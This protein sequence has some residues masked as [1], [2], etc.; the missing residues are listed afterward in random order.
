MVGHQVYLDVYDL[1]LPVAPGDGPGGEGA[2]RHVMLEAAVL[3]P[4]EAAPPAVDGVELDREAPAVQTVVVVVLRE[5]NLEFA[6]LGVNLDI[7]HGTCRQSSLSTLDTDLGEM[8]VRLDQTQR[9]SARRLQPDGVTLSPQDH[10]HH[11]HHHSLAEHLQ[12]F[13]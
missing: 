3:V 7:Y 2:A 1:A 5:D 12:T 11:H 4:A 10:H 8:T 13:S 6:E 9:R